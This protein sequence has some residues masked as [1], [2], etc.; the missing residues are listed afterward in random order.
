MIMIKRIDRLGR[1]L[2]PEKIRNELNI[3]GNDILELSVNDKGEMIIRKKNEVCAICSGQRN[4]V[5]I[6]KKY[7][8]KACRK[9]IGDK[10]I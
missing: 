2:I 7:I 6:D 3:N 8:C 1:V 10:R 9:K 5:R 4:L